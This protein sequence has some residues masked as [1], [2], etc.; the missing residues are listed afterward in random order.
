MQHKEPKLRNRIRSD[1]TKYR[2]YKMMD[3]VKFAICAI[4]GIVLAGSVVTIYVPDNQLL[5][6]IIMGAIGAIAGLAGNSVTETK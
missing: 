4:F 1:M 3:Q 5:S 6:N 2:G